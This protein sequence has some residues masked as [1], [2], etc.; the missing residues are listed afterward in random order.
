MGTFPPFWPSAHEA[1]QNGKISSNL[2]FCVKCLQ[3]YQAKPVLNKIK[4]KLPLNASYVA[5][6]TFVEIDPM[7]WKYQKPWGGSEVNAITTAKIVVSKAW[8]HCMP[9][10]K[11]LA[12]L[13]P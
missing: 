4:S 1:V 11:A 8:N 6:C 10:A 7:L 3:K 2:G 12:S 13:S 9:S 5:L